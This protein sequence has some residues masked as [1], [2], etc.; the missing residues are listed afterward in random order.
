[1]NIP[2]EEGSLPLRKCLMLYLRLL[3]QTLWTLKMKPMHIGK[4]NTN[5]FKQKFH[6]HFFQESQCRIY[7]WTSKQI[8]QVEC[9]LQH[10]K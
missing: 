6:R 7:N 4:K 8:Y 1:M 5:G 10:L 2:H 3:K 9:N